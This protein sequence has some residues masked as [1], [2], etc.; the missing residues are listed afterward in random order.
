MTTP[1]TPDHIQ[2]CLKVIE[3]CEEGSRNRC[4][5]CENKCVSRKHYEA[6]RDYI[7][8]HSLAEILL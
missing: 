4:P 1:Y 3:A 8:T 6:Y 7:M 5:F 2:D